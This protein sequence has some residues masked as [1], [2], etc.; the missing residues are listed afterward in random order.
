MNRIGEHDPHRREL[1]ELARKGMQAV[2]ER[3]AVDME[4][5]RELLADPRGALERHFGYNLPE[6]FNVAFVENL[7]DAT[8]V[9][10][11]M[12]GGRQSATPPGTAP[13]AGG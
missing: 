3:S 6:G 13:A 5:R 8:I 7:A 4:F 10:P 1:L 9:L 2:L 11:D 12:I